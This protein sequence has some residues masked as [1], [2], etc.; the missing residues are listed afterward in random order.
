MDI[1]DGSLTSLRKGCRTKPIQDLAFA[2]Q[3]ARP[4]IFFAHTSLI[5]ER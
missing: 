1:G 2:Q 3:S 5:F 4:R